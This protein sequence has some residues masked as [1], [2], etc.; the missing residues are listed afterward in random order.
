MSKGMGAVSKMLAGAG[1]IVAVATLSA[2]FVSAGVG[3]EEVRSTSDSLDVGLRKARLASVEL[4]HPVQF[5]V[6]PDCSWSYRVAGDS[7]DLRSTSS[8]IKGMTCKAALD[9]RPVAQLDFKPEGSV[10][11]NGRV[12]NQAVHIQIA[13]KIIRSAPHI[14]TILPSGLS[15]IDEKSS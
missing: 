2:P 12:I 11:T 1:I 10:F 7:T 15:F 4:D 3:S 14:E 9:G 6:N 8:L 13:S 5:T